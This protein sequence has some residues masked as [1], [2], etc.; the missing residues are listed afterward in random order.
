MDR[1]LL[2]AT[3]T[4]LADTGWD[5]LS[6]ERVAEE[7]GLS[8]VTLWRQGVTKESL[9]EGLLA[10][11]GDDYRR[12][13]WPVLTS[14]GTGRERLERA[15]RAACD[16][17]DGHLALL[18]TSDTVFHRTPVVSI[19]PFSR[20]LRDGVTDGSLQVHGPVDDV[21]QVLFNTVCYSY[22]HLRGR[23][24]WAREKTRRL[25]LGL[26]LPGLAP[27]SPDGAGA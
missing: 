2:D 27:P 7:A 26:V 16:V 12:E 25:I 18:L 1:K 10:D 24:R 22:I 11:L 13:L 8:R 6:L 4:V 19:E 23:H 17:F 15:L 3:V 9:I 20:L 14:A 21:A 5:G